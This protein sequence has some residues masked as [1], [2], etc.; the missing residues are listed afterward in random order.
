M[1]ETGEDLLLL[2]HSDSNKVEKWYQ[3]ILKPVIT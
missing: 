2:W 3:Y 1:Q